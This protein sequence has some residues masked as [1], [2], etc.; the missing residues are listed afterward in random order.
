M[1]IKRATHLPQ[2][3][4]DSFIRLQA[5]T[6]ICYEQDGLLL[7]KEEVF[8]DDWTPKQKCDIIC[9]LNQTI[10]QN[11]IVILATLDETIIGFTCVEPQ[12]FQDYLELSFIHISKPYRHQGIGQLIF[13]QTALEAKKLGAKKLYIG[14]HPSVDSQTF[15]AALGCTLTTNINQEIYQ[16]EPLDIQLEYLL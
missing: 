13:K 14:S 5:T 11:G 16:R 4:L 9:H 15:Y 6:H 8:I 7:T 10:E 12:P 1:Q 3:A 2:H